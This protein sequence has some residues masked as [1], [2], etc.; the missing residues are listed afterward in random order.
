M[1]VEL[2]MGTFEPRVGEQ[3]DARPTYSGEPLSLVLASCDE[4]PHARPG[5][6]A[7]ALLFD[8]SE[9]DRREQQIFRLE[10]GELGAFDLFLVPIAQA[11]QGIVYEAVIN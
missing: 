3:F 9:H 4:S 10:H 7:F 1:A 2:V 5:H 6:A 8:S 11:E